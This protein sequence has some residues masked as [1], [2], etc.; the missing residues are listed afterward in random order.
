MELSKGESLLQPLS[1]LLGAS[2]KAEQAGPGRLV[3]E[4]SDGGNDVSLQSPAT[5]EE[6]ARPAALLVP[7][8][9]GA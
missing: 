1:P 9:G 7:R 3:R 4:C 2:Q 5:R 6:Q 8:E